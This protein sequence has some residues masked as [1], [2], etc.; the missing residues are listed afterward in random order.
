MNTKSDYTLSVD[1]L[2]GHWTELA[3]KILKG[4]GIRRISVDMEL[5]AWRTLKSTMRA[6]LRWQ[7]AFRFST[8]VSLSTLMEES[9]RKAALLV[10]Q[11]FE[12]QSVSHE[13]ENRVRQLAAEQR[14]TPV[15]RALYSASV[16]KPALRAAFKQPSRTDFVPRL[17]LS[18]Q[19]AI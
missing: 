16:R 8:L 19:A 10:A 15:E 14:A 1:N 13:F 6:E 9:L 7:R 17:R 3:L 2:A 11:K 5:D 12:P 4:A 18:A